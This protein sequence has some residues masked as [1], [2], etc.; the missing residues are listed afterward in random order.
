MQCP[1]TVGT[2]S[3]C[4][5]NVDLTFR[6]VIVA[7]NVDLLHLNGKITTMPTHKISTK[8]NVSV[9]KP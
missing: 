2:H 3:I 9:Q 6:N 7:T 1:R 5:R 4:M 8:T